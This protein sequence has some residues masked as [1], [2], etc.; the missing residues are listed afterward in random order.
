[1]NVTIIWSALRIAVHYMETWWFNLATSP[2]VHP[3]ELHSAWGQTA[4]DDQ[5]MSYLF[6]YV[7]LP[8]KPIYPFAAGDPSP[9]VR[10]PTFHFVGLATAACLFTSIS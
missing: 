8:W 1:M 5:A 10:I 6:E 2:E 7:N 9:T 3:V 4:F